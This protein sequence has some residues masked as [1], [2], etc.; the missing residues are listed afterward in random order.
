MDIDNKQLERD[1]ENAIRARGLKE[2]MQQ[3][4]AERKQQMD[5]PRIPAAASVPSR[6][7]IMSPKK[8]S[9][10]PKLRRTIY[11]LSAVAVLAGIVVM[12]VPMSVWKSS[13]RQASHWAYQQYAHYFLP[14]QPKKVVYENSTE[15]LMAMATPSVNQIVTDRYELEI[16]GH[17][18][19]IQDAAW[20]I[21]KANYGV[22][23][24]ILADARDALSTDDAHYQETMDDIEYLEALCFLGQDRRTKAKKMLTTI[25]ESD[26][27]HREAAA[28]L[29]EDIK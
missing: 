28:Q 11:T 27:R 1:I 26:S 29:A 5:Y 22:A 23:E 3:W 20:Q 4:E 10:W 7:D 25:A 2:Q 16:L 9:R 18:D 24:Q 13:Y 15:T 8:P 14:S 12:A 21:Q 17:E 6:E 19:L